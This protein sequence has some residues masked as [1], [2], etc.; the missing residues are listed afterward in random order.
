VRRNRN[1]LYAAP[2]LGLF[3]LALSG[4]GAPAS[5]RPSAAVRRPRSAI[6]APS[7]AARNLRLSLTDPISP[8]T[9]EGGREFALTNTA[10][11]PC[12]MSVSPTRIALYDSGRRLPFDFAYDLR[13]GG[14][15]GVP[16]IGYC[17]PE[18]GDPRHTPGD[19]VSVSPIERRPPAGGYSSK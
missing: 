7:C 18:S 11:R 12:I 2:I 6:G 8:A 1:P 19:R 4:C 9:N 15:L 14:E 3:S 13:R 17:L 10:D 16:A 5:R